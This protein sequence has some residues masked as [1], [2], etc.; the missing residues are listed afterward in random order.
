MAFSVRSLGHMTLFDT[1]F[2]L[3]E[4]GTA[5]ALEKLR[6]SPRVAL[7]QRTV[8]ASYSTAAMTKRC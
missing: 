4:L 7:G 2:R 3:D 5:I 1:E 6:Q 8:G